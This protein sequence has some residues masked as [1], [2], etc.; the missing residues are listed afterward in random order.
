MIDIKIDNECKSKPQAWDANFDFTI[1][2]TGN[3]IKCDLMSMSPQDDLRDVLMQLGHAICKLAE[4]EE[5]IPA[6]I[7]LDDT[8]NFETTGSQLNARYGNTVLGTIVHNGEDSKF[9]K[10][11]ATK[12]QY[13]IIDIR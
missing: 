10:L 11:S 9:T 12:W 8:V 6:Q 13:E 1:T 2:Y 7:I 3:Q 5:P 4:G